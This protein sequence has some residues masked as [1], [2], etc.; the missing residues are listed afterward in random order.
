M[1]SQFRSQ[2][3]MEESD[4]SLWF[5]DTI[6]PNF[7]QLH[8]VRDT[9][10]RTETRFQSAQ[11]IQTCSFGKC[12]VLDEKIQSAEVDEFIYH[13]ALVHPAMIACANPRTVFVAGGG[14]GATLREILRYDSIE[15]VVMVDIDQETVDICRRFLPSMNQGAFDDARVELLHLDARAYLDESGE[16]FDVIIVDLTEPLEGGTSHPLYTRQFYQMV[17]DRLSPEGILAVQSGSCTFG[18]IDIFVAISSTLRSVFPLVLPYQAHVPS[19]GGPWGFS[20]ASHQLSPVP[21]PIKEVDKRIRQRL[22]GSLR[23]YDGVTHQGMFRLPRYVRQELRRGKTI[24]T[25]E[26][27]LFLH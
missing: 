13:E 17:Q 20:L 6:N 1:P 16:R 26:Q 14:E 5:R 23:F 12:L 11:I 9:I 15:K 8:R 27:P 24:I 3:V 2:G 22:S 7:V 21:M 25:D 4:R 18:D 10:L 19:F